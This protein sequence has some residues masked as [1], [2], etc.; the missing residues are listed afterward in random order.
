MVMEGALN[1][2]NCYFISSFNNDTKLVE[3]KCVENES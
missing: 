1:T 3:K 2:M